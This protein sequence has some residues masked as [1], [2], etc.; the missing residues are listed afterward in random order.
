MSLVYLIKSDLTAA[1]YARIKEAL[2]V[3][4]FCFSGHA[5]RDF[6]CRLIP[7]SSTPLEESQSVLLSKTLIVAESSDD[8][9]VRHI[10]VMEPEEEEDTGKKVEHLSS[11]AEVAFNHLTCT[12]EFDLILSRLYDGLFRIRQTVRIEVNSPA[13]KHAS[14]LC[15]LIIMGVGGNG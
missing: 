14:Y 13:H 1:V 12:A 9:T 7:I 4:N 8:P 15:E 2:I 3:A 5:K 10:Q 11:T 6:N